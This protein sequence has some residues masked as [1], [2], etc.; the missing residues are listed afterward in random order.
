MATRSILYAVGLPAS[1]TADFTP[2]VSATVKTVCPDIE[3]VVDRRILTPS[4]TSMWAWGNP[5]PAQGDARG[6]GQ[7]GMAPQP[8]A[9]FAASR[10]LSDVFL[11]VPFASNQ[12]VAI[13]TWLSGSVSALHTGGQRVSALGGDYGWVANPDLAVQWM[14]AARSVAPVD[15]VELDVEPW[16]ENP[17][18]TSDEADIGQYIGLVR[19]A[20]ATAHSLGMTFGL[21]A[22]WWLATTP[23]QSGT[24]LETLL[25]YV[26]RV[27]I[28]S[29][30]DHGGRMDGIIAQAWMAVTQT[31]AAHVPFTIGVQTSSDA[32]AGGSQYTFA[33]RGSAALEG[34]C[35]TVRSA[36]E[37]APGYAG[38]TVEEY[39]S[40]AT[41][42]P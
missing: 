20:E 16:T 6:L 39:L 31:V 10:Q 12:G 14:T 9:E 27:S 15:G 13:S 21:D 22:P 40:W 35:L 29:Y 32:I 34:E 23:Y 41:L 19:Q 33:D 30:S 36:Y 18:W 1:S 8:L 5:V 17:N 26:D 24:A 11:S 3:P 28:V 7:P 42:K 4:I 25:H 38:I 37:S 2:G